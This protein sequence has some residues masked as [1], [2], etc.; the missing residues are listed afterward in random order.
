MGTQREWTESQVNEVWEQGTPVEE[1]DADVFRM[2]A[3]GALIRRDAYGNRRNRFGWEIDEIVRPADGSTGTA[4]RPLFCKNIL[5]REER[6]V[7]RKFFRYHS[8]LELN[9]SHF[10]M[11]DI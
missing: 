11:N 10:F 5:A 7:P 6:T 3:A 1:L 8:A 4:L 9:V 2:D